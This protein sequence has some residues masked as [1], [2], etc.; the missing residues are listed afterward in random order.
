M[1]WSIRIGIENF[2]VTIQR[3]ERKDRRENHNEAFQGKKT[4][5]SATS[6]F[7]AVKNATE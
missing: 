1:K 2:L 4:E 7:S 3:R 5:Y 6:A